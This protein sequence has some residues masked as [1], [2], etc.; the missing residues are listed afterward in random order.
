MAVSISQSNH[1]EGTVV[2][3]MHTICC[4][5]HVPLGV[6]DANEAKRRANN[7]SRTC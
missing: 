7:S 6:A 5:S 1:K 2:N 4:T 3:K